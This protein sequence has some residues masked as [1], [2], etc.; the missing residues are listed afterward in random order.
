[1]DR[2][3]GFGLGVWP[4]VRAGGRGAAT[5]PH[6]EAPR[7]RMDYNVV[8]KERLET[9]FGVEGQG[10]VTAKYRF[11]LEVSGDKSKEIFQN[12]FSEFKKNA[13][14][15]GFRK[16][17]IPPFMKVEINRF[18]L[19][20]CLTNSLSSA[21]EQN[22]LKMS[23]GDKV[24]PDY[25]PKV[26][27]MRKKFKPGQPIEYTVEVACVEN[28]EASQDSSPAPDASEAPETGES[29]EAKVASASDAS[30]PQQ[31]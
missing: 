7:W 28:S 13:K 21:L 29:T 4:V 5:C 22:N 14:F 9:L 30:D 16:G 10:E 31:K 8:S 25:S 11:G 6:A 23:E 26:S 20:E 24:I 27:E 18:A 2:Q 1:M 17:Q 15:P 19:E 3:L 12:I